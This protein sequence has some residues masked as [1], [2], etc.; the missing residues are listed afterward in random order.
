LRRHGGENGAAVDAVRV[1]SP[2]IRL[3]AGV[4][5][6]VAARYRK[7]ARVYF[8]HRISSAGIILIRLTGI[9]SAPG[10]HGRQHPDNSDHYSTFT[11][12]VHDF[13]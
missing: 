5:S 6:A 1:E 7:A 2:E 11:A 13:A 4:A 8:S 3:Y 12:M 9:F 10:R